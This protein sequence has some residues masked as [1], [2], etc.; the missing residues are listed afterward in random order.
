MLEQFYST[1]HVAEIL[2][3]T[4]K[5]VERWRRKGMLRSVKAGKLCRYPESEINRFLGIGDDGETFANDQVNEDE[6][7]AAQ[8]EAETKEDWPD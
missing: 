3:V 4:T 8:R 2:A 7:L 5:A 6:L 1:K